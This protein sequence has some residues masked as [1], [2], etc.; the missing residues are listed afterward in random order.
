MQTAGG[1][2]DTPPARAHSNLPNNLTIEIGDN[3][4]ITH[5]RKSDT[6]SIRHRSNTIHD[7]GA[8]NKT[9]EH[10]LHLTRNVL[11]TG[12]TNIGLPA[13]SLNIV[14]CQRNLTGNEHHFIHWLR[15][16]VESR[17][18]CE[19]SRRPPR[20]SSLN[21]NART[22]N[23]RIMSK[24]IHK[25]IPDRT[26][27]HVLP[28]ERV[29]FQLGAASPHSD[30]HGADRRP[31]GQHCQSRKLVPVNMETVLIG[32]GKN[33]VI[34]LRHAHHGS[35]RLVS[36]TTVVRKLPKKGGHKAIRQKNVLHIHYLR[37]TV[38]PN[39][40][41]PIRNVN[42]EMRVIKHDAPSSS[43]TVCVVRNCGGL[44]YS[45][46]PPQDPNSRYETERPDNGET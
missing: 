15:V 39:T 26:L 34:N 18:M 19:R 28:T 9:I 25:M 22:Q 3:Q 40:P 46:R 38:Q 37:C 30:H 33:T 32:Q 2:L 11:A 24:V 45:Q 10:F 17:R 16:N 6:T 7:R 5:H 4:K 29:N 13:K 31:A 12:H 14:H 1:K 35:Q 44:P 43:S 20:D 36:G 42:G 8:H 21:G 41:R 23:N 27:R